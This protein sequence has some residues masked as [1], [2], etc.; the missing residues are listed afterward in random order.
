MTQKHVDLYYNVKHAFSCFKL[1]TTATGHQQLTTHKREDGY[2]QA[3]TSKPNTYIYMPAI[4]LW[5][6]KL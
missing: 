4:K 2:G 3:I 5:A 6:P 1:G